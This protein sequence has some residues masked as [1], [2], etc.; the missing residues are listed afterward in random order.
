MEISEIIGENLKRIRKERNLSLG[1]LS[2]MSDVSKMMLSQIEKGVS[3]PSI[4]TVWKIADALELPYTS[5]LDQRIEGGTVISSKDI[6]VQAL[7]G[8]HGFLR[9]YYHNSEKRNFELFQMTIKPTKS[10]IAQGHGERT[11]E[12]LYVISGTLRIKLDDGEH[13]LYGGDAISFH[14]DKEHVYVNEEDEDLKM[15]MINYYR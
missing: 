11:D 6:P 12:Y 15:I 5:L 13:V 1:Q 14:S 8:D 7:D 2:T 9:C 10:Y 4:N 3:N